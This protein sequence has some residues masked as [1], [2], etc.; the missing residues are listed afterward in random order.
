MV[1]LELIRSFWAQDASEPTNVFEQYPDAGRFAAA[2]WAEGVL[3]YVKATFE[4]EE[5]HCEGKN[6]QTNLQNSKSNDER[7]KTSFAYTKSW[8]A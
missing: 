6:A 5:A 3:A 2:E 7:L 8:D 4:E 1:G